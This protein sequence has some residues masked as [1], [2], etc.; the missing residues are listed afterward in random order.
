MVGVN[1]NIFNQIYKQIKKY[2]KIVIARH[3]GAD[4]DAL[5]STLGLKEAILHNLGISIMSTRLVSQG[6]QTGTLGACFVDNVNLKRTFNIVY[7]RNK[8]LSEPLM[9]FIHISE[10]MKNI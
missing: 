10:N 4:P 6:L 3:I 1:M 9:Q 2:N 5:G 8:L 7:R